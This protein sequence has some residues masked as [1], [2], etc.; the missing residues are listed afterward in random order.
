MNK[1][2]IYLY[3]V[4]FINQKK[5]QKKNKADKN[6]NTRRSLHYYA[7]KITH[8]KQTNDIKQMLQKYYYYYMVGGCR[9]N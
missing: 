7:V 3:L 6:I 2:H 5:K 9:Y 4:R 1:T 8:N